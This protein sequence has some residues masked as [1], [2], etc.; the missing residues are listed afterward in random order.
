[1]KKLPDEA[2][3][4]CKPRLHEELQQAGVTTVIPMGNSAVKAVFPKDQSRSGITKLRVG[5]P[6]I[7]DQFCVVPTF[8]PAACLRNQEKFPHML[9]DIGKAVSRDNLPDNWYE[10]NIFVITPDKSPNLMIEALTGPTLAF[11]DIET[12]REKDTSYGNV[13]ME[14]LLCV[15]I[16]IEGEDS[17]F[18]F[19][20]EC[21]QQA[22]FRKR[23]MKF[24]AT[25]NL[26]AQN[27]KFDLG[28]LR[29]YLGYP[30]FEGPVLSEDTMLQSYALFE[31]QGVHGLEYMG[32]ELL[33]T[34]DWKHAIA[35]YLKGP[36]GKQPTDY[37][38]IPP[39]ILYKYNA[40]DVHVTR[41]LHTYFSKELEKRGLVDAYRFML[42]VSNMLTLV[43]PRGF[44]FDIPYSETLSQQ[45]AAEREDLERGLP[46][47]C[48][49]EAKGK[50]LRI[51]HKLNVDSPDQVKQYYTKNGVDLDNT[52]ADTLR[53]LLE[54]PRIT[55]P[56]I[57]ATTQL[58]LDIR[59]ITK[60][61][62]TFVTGLQ[63]KTT[64][65]GTVHPSFLIHGTTSGRLSARNPN[66]Q[67]IPRAKQIK[68]QFISR[69]EDRIL[70]G[71]DMS[72]AELRVLT[73]LAQEEL[74]RDIFNDPS[75]DLFVEL[76]RSMF[77]D[78]YPSS[79]GDKEVKQLSSREAPGEPSIRTLVK[80]FAYGIAYGRTAAGIAADPQF[81]MDVKV[82]QKHMRVFERT[83]PNTIAFLEDAADRA[84]KGEA[85]ITPFGRHRRFHLVTPQNKHSVRNEAKSFYAQSI[86]SDIVLEAACRLTYDHHIFIVNLVH[87][88]IY[89]DVPKKDA[90]SV[91]D[92]ISHVMVQV[93]E[94]VTEGYVRFA[95]EGK[96]SRSWADV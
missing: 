78:R 48:N 57:R 63:K 46:I 3:E 79:M 49:P 2:I 55:D 29:A 42:R 44:G 52:E 35:P 24:L 37:G 73:W 59:A 25:N 88:A 26:G 18:V 32:Q 47:V 58:I 15:G 5:R 69:S 94:E 82:A 51:P 21:F 40:F 83:I 28:S 74:T 68:R 86:A 4:C 75:R 27:G 87:D 70:V 81:Q 96:I 50:H 6:K 93:G 10:P 90:E 66:S 9:S 31:Y 92:L 72:Q 77:P 85:L 89:A 19:T 17:V 56:D 53:L 11:L 91:R 95:A 54:D 23:F 16:G 33:G 13:H 67:N 20:E 1:M 61:D 76:C 8:H 71:V 39:D 64:P 62:G 43:E 45:Y 60:M 30:D 22:E 80:T 84:C 38:N 12:S 34:S 7:L 65:E 41:L 36:D 14:K